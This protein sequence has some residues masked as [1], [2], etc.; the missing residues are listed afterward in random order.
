MRH[1]KIFS[2]FTH[3][4]QMI[5]TYYNTVVLTIW[6]D[7]GYEYIMNEFRAELNKRGILQQFTYPYTLEQNVVSEQKLSYYVYGLVF[8]KGD[9]HS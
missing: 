8:L 2:H 5:K 4:L 3:F 9:G 6:S 1:T 7:N